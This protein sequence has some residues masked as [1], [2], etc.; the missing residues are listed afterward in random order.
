MFDQTF[1]LLDRLATAGSAEADAVYKTLILVLMAH[2]KLKD[3]VA[4]ESLLQNF[5]QLFE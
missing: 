4:C 3:E 1:V 5:Q 2:Y